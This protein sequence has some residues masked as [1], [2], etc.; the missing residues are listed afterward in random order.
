MIV[1]ASDHAGVEL[2]AQI[3]A[4]VASL[5]QEVRDLGPE[6]TASV[7][8]PDYAHAV[9]DAVTAREAERGILINTYTVNTACEKEYMSRLP[10]A[11][12]TN[13]PGKACLPDASDLVLENRNWCSLC[14]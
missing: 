2:K 9:A 11:Y 5:G 3:V 8:Y 12:T 4:L 7:D 10:V 6:Q 13:C 1:I 14:E